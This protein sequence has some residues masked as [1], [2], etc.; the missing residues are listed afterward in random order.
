MRSVEE[1]ASHAAPGMPALLERN[2]RFVRR[3]VEA[4]RFVA[5]PPCVFVYRLAS[6]GH[7]QRGVVAE[8]PIGA[9]LDGRI[10]RHEFTRVAR[11]DALAQYIDHVRTASSPVSLAYRA[12]EAI[13][14]RLDAATRVRPAVSHT[15]EDGVEHDIWVLDGADAHSLIGAFETVSTAY[16]TD[17]HPPVR[18]DGQILDRRRGRP[19]A[20]GALSR[21]RAS[22]PAVPSCRA[23]P[24]RAFHRILPRPPLRELH[25]RTAAGRRPGS[26]TA[27]HARRI[28]GPPRG[29]V[30]PISGCPTTGRARRVRRTRSTPRF[31]RHGSSGRCSASSIPATTIA[32]ATSPEREDSSSSS[33]PAG[34]VGTRPSRS[35]RRAWTSSSPSRT[36]GR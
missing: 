8:M 13:R 4:G 21:R 35:I 28:R 5:Q 18:R 12:D 34:R 32:S 24:R 33:A 15:T 22:N 23:R 29:P 6:H 3:Y 7:V 19:T 16:L 2:A 30:V 11:E 9:Y 27:A 36:P 1:Y 14:N 17:G 31:C 20:R 10:R 26:R 25:R